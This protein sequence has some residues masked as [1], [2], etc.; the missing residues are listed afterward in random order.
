VWLLSCAPQTDKTLL[1]L[2]LLLLS[3]LLQVEKVGK[4]T[5]RVVAELRQRLSNLQPKADKAAAASEG[6]TQE[7]ERLMEVRDVG[8]SRL[9]TPETLLLRFL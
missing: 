3:H 6:A 2:L 5:Q 9:S 1:L 8:P 7:K 4:F